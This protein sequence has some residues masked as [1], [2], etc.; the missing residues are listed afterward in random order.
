MTIRWPR[1]LKRRLIVQLLVLQL[2]IIVIVGM[3]VVMFLVH[4]DEGGV[5]VSPSPVEIAFR[6][7]ERDGNGNLKLRETEELAGLLK[8][9]PDFWFVAETRAGERIGI[10]QVPA[11]YEQISRNLDRITYSD[12]RDTAAD[13][14]YLAVI[15]HQSGPAGDFTVFGKAALFSPTFIVFFF[16]NLFVAPI[17]VMLAIVTVFAI[18]WIV[19]RSVA[20]LADVADEAGRID[21]D[22][23]GYRLADAN[24]PT[25]VQPLVRAVN[26]ALQRLDDGYE[27]HQRFILDAAHELRTPVAI[28]QTRVETLDDGPIRSRLLADAARIA[29]LAEQ[30]LDIQRLDSS[31]RT[32][33]PVELID[34]SRSVVADMA[35]MAIAQ[36]HDLAFEARVERLVVHGDGSALQRAIANIVRNAIEHAGRQTSINVRVESGSID[37]CDN[38]RGVPEHEKER[39]FD[40]FHRLHPRDRGAGLGLNLVREIMQ[41]HGGQVTVHDSPQGGACFRLTFPR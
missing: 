25:E 32:F 27:R 7:I 22:R 12:L 26:G 23:R 29:S 1:S 39:I 37:I 18:P 19:S 14:S 17:L 15:R 6:A 2:S 8:T 30:L 41:L 13:P 31:D 16:S 21:V 40:A 10:G 38:G 24:V 36:G 3:C 35:P 5:L 28:L 34:L 4:A 11:L 20:S 9:V 33:G